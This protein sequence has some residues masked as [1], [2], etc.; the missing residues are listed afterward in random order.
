M[1]LKIPIDP[2]FTALKWAY[3]Q[4]LLSFRCFWGRGPANVLCSFCIWVDYWPFID[5]E[6]EQGVAIGQ[7]MTKQFLGEGV[8]AFSNSVEFGFALNAFTRAR[9]GVWIL[10][11]SFP[12]GDLMHCSGGLLLCHPKT[13]ASGMPCSPKNK[14]RIVFF[15]R[16]LTLCLVL[17]LSLCTFFYLVAQWLFRSD[18]MIFSCF[19]FWTN[20]K[21]RHS[22]DTGRKRD[23]QNVPGEKQKC[24]TAP[25][26]RGSVLGP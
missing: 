17:G 12:F 15:V 11:P 26:R 5:G 10:Q 7:C 24:V 25:W 9:E 19:F 16:M 22:S 14:Y 23:A 1:M 2:P 13:S 8:E 20:T 21:T 4:S 6:N 18:L 3:I